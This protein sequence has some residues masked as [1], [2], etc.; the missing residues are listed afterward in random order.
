MQQV[1]PPSQEGTRAEESGGLWNPQPGK[2]TWQGD[3]T[4]AK[5]WM[6]LSSVPSAAHDD[7][8]FH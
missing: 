6:H 4:S 2:L 7:K 1:S 8:E 3:E 5:F